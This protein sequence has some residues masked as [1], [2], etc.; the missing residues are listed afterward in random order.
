[1]KISNS[2]IEMMSSRTYSQMYD[3]KEHLRVWVGKERPDFEGSRQALENISRKGAYVGRLQQ[4]SIQAA[5][6]VAAK[7]KSQ[8]MAETS[9]KRRIKTNGKDELKIIIVEKAVEILTGKKIKIE[10]IDEVADCDEVKCPQAQQETSQV[11]SKGSPAKA[12][13]GLEYDYH[14]LYVEKEKVTFK[15]KGIINT[16]DGRQIEFSVKLNMSRQFMEKHDISIRAG[17][18]VK[19]DPLVINFNGLASELTETKYDFDLDFDGEKERIS[20]VK[21]GSGLLVLDLNEDGLINNG[22]ELFGP[23]TGDG[24]SEL[25]S[26][27][28]DGNNWIDENDSVFYKLKIW[29]KDTEAHDLLYSLGQKGVGAIYLGHVNTQFDLK[30]SANILQGQIKD[31]GIFVSEDGVI[32]TLQQVDFA[33]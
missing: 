33:V 26:Y 19:V 17:D 13:W 32:G 8:A 3:R 16:E 10:T 22:S 6:M 20:F 9:L 5:E 12:G 29:S 23:S 15:A 28:E 25:A 2:S 7:D 14:E 4:K 1:M 31:S 21:Q 18:A 24:L 27:D 11:E 30:D